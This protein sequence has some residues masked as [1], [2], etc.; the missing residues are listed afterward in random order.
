MVSRKATKSQSDGKPRRLELG[1]EGEKIGWRR[2]S[3][4]VTRLEG[5]VLLSSVVIRRSRPSPLWSV[6]CWRN[7]SKKKNIIMMVIIIIIVERWGR[8]VGEPK[9]NGEEPRREKIK[10]QH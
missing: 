9:K 7:L 6:A 4:K 3:H 1:L 8:R 10:E 2:K 5:Q